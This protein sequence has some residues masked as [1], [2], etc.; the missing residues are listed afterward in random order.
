[1]VDLVWWKWLSPWWSMW[2]RREGQALCKTWSRSYR[3]CFPPPQALCSSYFG[4]GPPKRDVML[5]RV[6][7]NRR[8][9]LCWSPLSRWFVRGG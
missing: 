5:L 6:P 8:T 4:I 3:R 1:M 9:V 2:F 7:S